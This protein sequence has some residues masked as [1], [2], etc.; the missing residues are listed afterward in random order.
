MAFARRG[1]RAGALPR[2]DPGVP[3]RTVRKA[4][5]RIRSAA[6]IAGSVLL[7]SLA[8][9]ACSS[10][11][12]TPGSGGVTLT[13][14]DWYTSGGSSDAVNWYNQRFEAAHPG[15]TIQRETV[16]STSYMTKLLQEASARDL[17]SI[18]MVDNPD[19]QEMAA[20]GQLSSLDGLPGFTT[21]D[22]YPGAM[23]ECRYQGKYYCYPVGSNTVALFYNKKMLADAH[24]T[25][26]TTWAQLAADAKAL[27]KPKAGVYGMAF[28]AATAEN[29][30]FQF[31][32]YLWS[33]GGSLS[34]VSS[35]AA[36]QALTLWTQ[37]VKDGSVSQS[38]LNWAQFPD[39]YEQF[40]HGTAA[41]AE[42]G[43]WILPS[44]TAAGWKYGVQYGIAP[45]PAPSAGQKVITPLGGETWALSSSGNATEQKLSWEW[46]Q[47]L[48]QPAVMTH[49]EKLFNYLPPKPSVAATVTE[50][51]PAFAVF[52]NELN[53]AQ[54]RTTVYGSNYPKVSNAL[55]VAIQAAISNAQSPSAALSQA[56][57]TISAIPELKSS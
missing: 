5:P 48:Q 26:P 4:R 30:T 11:G 34:N 39:V 19:V 35:P 57:G 38:V 17:P 3:G 1:K 16:P 21:S 9:A 37:M 24:L 42:N 12:S 29:G 49:V 41:M 56:Q 28:S 44:L 46:L 40:V 53:T 52:A 22:Y 33:N 7:I 31:E 54:P 20:T 25:P 27:T 15:V 51:N 47:G 43:P 8:A 55:Q 6:V 18:V 14:I 45:L 10:S 32:P 2:T 13:E 36:E 50:A 23:Q